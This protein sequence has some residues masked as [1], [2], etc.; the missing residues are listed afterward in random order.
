MSKSE[1]R[2]IGET[3]WRELVDRQPSLETAREVTF[4][5]DNL[6]HLVLRVAVRAYT[7]GRKDANGDNLFNRLFGDLSR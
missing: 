7:Q 4:R 6:R 5:V 3:C 1:E 2:E